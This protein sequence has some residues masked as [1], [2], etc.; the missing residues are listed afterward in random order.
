MERLFRFSLHNECQVCNAL[1]VKKKKISKIF[2]KINDLVKP[3]S[4]TEVPRYRNSV[5]YKR[6]YCKIEFAVIKKLAMDPSKA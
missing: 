3:K 5:C 2:C 4:Y 6:F 1:N